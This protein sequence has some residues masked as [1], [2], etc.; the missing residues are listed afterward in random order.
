MPT[1]DPATTALILI[2]LQKGIVAGDKGPR[3]AAE[4]VASAKDLASRFRA[5]G[6]LVARRWLDEQGSALTHADRVR[7]GP[8]FDAASRAPVVQELRALAE[9]LSPV[10]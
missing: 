8:I 1:F 3:S 2:D 5:A 9:P 6:A 4:V 7:L 10:A